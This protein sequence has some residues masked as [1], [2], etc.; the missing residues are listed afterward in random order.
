MPTHGDSPQSGP[1]ARPVPVV[2]AHGDLDIE[3]LGPLRQALETAAEGPAVVLDASGVTFADSSFLS[4]LL[5]VR[6]LTDLRVA[7]APPQVLRLLEITGADRIIPLYPSV[8]E[9]E[10]AG[11]TDPV[12]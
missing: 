10:K 6:Q 11:R 8:A 12:D 3:N 7:G 4:V 9:A 2:A 5:G 1:A